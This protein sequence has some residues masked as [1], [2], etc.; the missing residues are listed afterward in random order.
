M[1][2]LFM[3]PLVLMLSALRASH[4]RGGVLAVLFVIVVMLALLVTPWFIGVGDAFQERFLLGLI[5]LLFP[6]LWTIDW[7]FG[8][9]HVLF[10]ANV[11]FAIARILHG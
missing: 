7:L 11:W 9:V 6:G 3:L 4:A 8:L 10:H 2:R 1:L 5:F